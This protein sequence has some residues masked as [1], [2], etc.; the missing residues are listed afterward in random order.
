MHLLSTILSLRQRGEV[1]GFQKSVHFHGAVS[2]LRGQCWASLPDS[3]AERAKYFG[4]SGLW[5]GAYDWG[6]VRSAVRTA[7]AALQPSMNINNHKHCHEPYNFNR[8]KRT[9]ETLDQSRGKYG[10]TVGV[11]YIMPC[12]YICSIYIYI[13]IHIHIYIY[14]L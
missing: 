5:F 8:K 6:S 13:Y 14:I 9:F 2:Q 7:A 4:V 11:R 10:K 3:L 1:T 12:L